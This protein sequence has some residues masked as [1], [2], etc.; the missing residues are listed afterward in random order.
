V[1][2]TINLDPDS[3]VLDGRQL[4]ALI[5]RWLE[6][7]RTKHPKLT[8]DGYEFKINYFREWWAEVGPWRNWELS[9]DI[10][11]QFAAWLDTTTTNQKKPL[12]YNTKK[13]ILRRLRQCLRWAYRRGFTNGRDF[14]AW[15]PQPEGGPPLRVAA[16]QDDLQLL[17]D[18]AGRGPFPER[19]Q[20][21]LALFI[22]T[23]IRRSEC[24]SI[25]IE[26]IRM[27]EDL[28]GAMLVTGKRTKARPTGERMVAFD[29]LAGR[30]VAV[31]LRN[32]G[33]TS[34][35]LFCGVDGEP[36]SPQGIYKSVKRAI[37]AAGLSDKIIGPHDLR[38]A[39]ITDWRRRNRGAGYDHLLRM[40]VGHVKDAVTDLYDL[41][42]MED[43]SKV[44]SGPLSLLWTLPV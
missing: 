10:L 17:L 33:G 34:G 26:N 3:D 1:K 25:L 16:I 13:D 8:V 29:S 35:R 31:H 5:N 21:I 2:H 19:D 39:F 38:R 9:E 43:L 14:S 20:A 15:V 22:Q 42:D 11:I 30:F 7:S 4:P 6:F 27:E 40:Q 18:A 12:S 41:S 36:L 32:C 37:S 23:G 24:A 44:M 28:S